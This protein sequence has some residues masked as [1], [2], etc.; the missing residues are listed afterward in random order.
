M[1]L[2][3]DVKYKIASFDMDTWIKLSYI[4]NEFKTFSYGIGRKLF[5]DLFT[6][7][8]EDEYMKTWKIFGKYHS[9]ND[10]PAI[11]YACGEKNWYQNGQLHRNNDL[12]AIIDANGTQEWYQN[13][14]RH[15]NNDQPAVI[16]TTGDKFWW[17]NG[18]YHRDN[19]QPAKRY[20]NGIKEWYQDGQ[21]ILKDNK[22]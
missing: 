1:D 10:Q 17:R 18:Q 3:I 8:Y 16:C 22:Q 20:V 2:P 11:I 12:P 7:F 14:R 13:G 19:D 15:R 21:L 5:I 9:F 4:D 6:I